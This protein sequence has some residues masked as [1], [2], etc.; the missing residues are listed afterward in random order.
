MEEEL[1]REACISLALLKHR[2][3]T[4][5]MKGVSL[6]ELLNIKMI[7]LTHLMIISIQ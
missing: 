4:R 3:H 6:K 1:Y 2:Q 5:D 7:G